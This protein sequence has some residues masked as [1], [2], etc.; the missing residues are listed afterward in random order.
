MQLLS[1]LKAFHKL[2]QHDQLTSTEIAVYIQLVLFANNINW[3][4]WISVPNSSL[5]DMAGIA[6]PETL[7]KARSRLKEK[8]YLDIRDGK[9]GVAPAYKI[10]DLDNENT[11]KRLSNSLSNSPSNS[12][13]NSLSNSPLYRLRLRLRHRRRH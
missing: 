10:V 5:L 13:S 11:N 6:R 7:R 9:K 8:G 1:Q 12:L 3:P 2:S 4:A